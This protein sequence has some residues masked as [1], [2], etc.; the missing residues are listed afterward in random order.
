LSSASAGKQRVSEVLFFFVLP[1]VGG[2]LAAVAAMPATMA[3]VT[4]AAMTNSPEGPGR[5]KA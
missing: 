1:I 5:K 4:V 2:T 3:M